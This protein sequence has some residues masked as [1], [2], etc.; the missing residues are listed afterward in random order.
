[1]SCLSCCMACDAYFYRACMAVHLFVFDGLCIEIWILECGGLMNAVKASE[2]GML[3][4]TN[5]R[6]ASCAPRQA[7]ENCSQ[8]H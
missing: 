2:R 8:R 6:R 3:L 4:T 1:M 7:Q 5:R